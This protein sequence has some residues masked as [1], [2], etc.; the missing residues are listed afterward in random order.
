[1]ISSTSACHDIMMLSCHHHH[2]LPPSW[3]HIIIT[4]TSASPPALP[5]P[6]AACAC[7]THPA[8]GAQLCHITHQGLLEMMTE[9]VMIVMMMMM[10][11][12]K[13][14][15]QERRAFAQQTQSIMETQCRLPTATKTIITM[16]ANKRK[17]F[18]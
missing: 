4:M 10:M 11:M 12:I 5:S 17:S 16:I 2:C 8:S 15:H 7:P 9:I 18:S 6:R 13:G 1:M 3:H 14:V